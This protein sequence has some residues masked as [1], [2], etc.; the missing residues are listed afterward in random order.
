MMSIRAVVWRGLIPWFIRD[1]VVIG[2]NVDGA[3]AA[4]RD[5]VAGGTPD[6]VAMPRIG[7]VDDDNDLPVAESLASLDRR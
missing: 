1:G 6:D 3:L 4:R 2:D 7:M 5:G